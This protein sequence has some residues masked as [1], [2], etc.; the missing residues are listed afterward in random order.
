MIEIEKVDGYLMPANNAEANG[1]IM[2]RVNA[3]HGWLMQE[4]ESKYFSNDCKMVCALMG[5][6]DVLRHHEQY[7]EKE[8]A[9]ATNSD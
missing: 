9:A 5:F 3:M 1:E 8:K 6:A 7:A 2:G 4:A